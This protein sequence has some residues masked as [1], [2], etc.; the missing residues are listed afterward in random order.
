M[1]SLS[2]EDIAAAE[3]PP[4]VEQ[5]DEQQRLAAEWFGQL[6]APVTGVA[7]FDAFNWALAVRN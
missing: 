4:L 7:S 6:P 1:P 2:K 3:Y 5:L